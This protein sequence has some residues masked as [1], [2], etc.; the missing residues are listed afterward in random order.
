MTLA[1]LQLDF[2]A[3][4]SAADDAA[5]P[6]PLGMEIY[7]NAYRARLLTA[8]EVSYERT[9]RW[10]GEAA[11]AEAACHYVI[12]HP[13]RD[14]TLDRFGAQFPPVLAILFANDAEVAELA[15]LEWHL[16]QA[17]AAPDLPELTGLQLAQAGL[18]EDDWEQL[19]LTMSA[20]YAALPV[21][22]DCTALWQALRDDELAGFTL[23]PTDP[24]VLVVWRQA[25]TPRFRVLDSG[26]FT[27]LETLAQG[28]P[29][30]RVASIVGEAGAAQLGGW[31]AQWLSEGLFAGFTVTRTNPE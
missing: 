1:L 26:E 17:F 7:R 6:G 19:C 4:L 22:H 8:L 14:W 13:P 23:M 10:V 11:F 29:F 12:S 30:G 24:G 2:A 16:Q 5:L 31:F 15:W 28:Q 18:R 21:R 3:E 27:A 25:L 9:R 20:G